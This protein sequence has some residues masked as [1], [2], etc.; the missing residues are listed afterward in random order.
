MQ[1][2]VRLAFFAACLGFALVLSSCTGAGD[3]PD[4]DTSTSTSPSP[5][6]P[7]V[8]LTTFSGA[9]ED[10]EYSFDHPSNW[11]VEETDPAT[12]PGY[13][14][15]AVTGPQGEDLASLD[16]LLT[17]DLSC[18]QDGC[19]EQ[20]VVYLGDWAGPDPLSVTGT[21]AA[22]SV[23]MDLS[24]NPSERAKYEWPDNVRVV[25]SLTATAVPPQSTMIPMLMYGM[26]QVDT[27]VLDSN[28]SI[29][30]TVLFISNRDFGTL[31]EARAYAASDEHRQIQ[32]MIASFR[33][34]R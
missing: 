34:S 33:E 10:V 14:T 6:S 3:D 27:E 13:G 22:R 23:A 32:A 4:P 7:S 20:P 28:G 5:S 24:E 9:R 26:V 31:E 25:T 30:R 18:M 19:P 2:P 8:A 17:W 1:R 16:I 12:G 11:T 15:V 21:I 29:R